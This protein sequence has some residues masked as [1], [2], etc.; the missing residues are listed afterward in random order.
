MGA[1]RRFHSSTLTVQGTV[2]VC[3]ISA[4]AQTGANGVEDRAIRTSE[5]AR[6]AEAE[7]RREI[8]RLGRWLYRLGFMPGSSGN[9][10]V[11]LDGQRLLATPTGVS[12]YLLRGEDL[13][14]VDMDGRQL[15]GVRRVTS[16]IDMHLAIYRRRQDVEAVVHAHPAAATAMAC[17]GR[18]L[19]EI[20]CQEAVMALGPVPLARYATTGTQQVA[21][22]LEP[23]IGEHQAIL[24]ANHGAVSYGSSLMDAFLKM[25]TLEHLAQIRLMAQQFGSPRVL[26]KEQLE[27]MMHARDRY[28]RNMT[29]THA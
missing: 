23:F 19:D 2:N 3:E 13:V 15:A 20:L 16:E 27:Q 4:Q 9:L 25:E 21:A 8:V 7:S 14:V 22:S 24:L 18:A 6:P 10:S 29:P 26:G 5:A 1:A 17:C 11:R 28:M 12:K